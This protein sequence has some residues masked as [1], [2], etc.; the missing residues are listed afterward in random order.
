MRESINTNYEVRTQKKKNYRHEL[1]VCLHLV[2]KNNL[3]IFFFIIR[4]C[5]EF[6][7]LRS[8]G[9][10]FK[11]FTTYLRVIRIDRFNKDIKCIIRLTPI[12]KLRSIITKTTATRVRL[13]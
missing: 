12:N 3:T 7:L 10:A 1:K 2:N 11:S 9:T 5:N 8:Y 6:E 13:V 4:N